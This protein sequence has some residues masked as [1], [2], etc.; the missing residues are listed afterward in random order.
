[1]SMSF[2]SIRASF[3]LLIFV[4]LLVSG[5]KRG[6]HFGAVPVSGMVTLDGE[7]IEGVSITF[8]P[9]SDPA[10]TA[11]GMSDVTGKFVLTTG[12]SKFGT[13]AVPGDYNVILSK[14][15][16]VHKMVSVDE[17]NAGNTGTP[18]S[19]EEAFKV[20]RHIPQK[21][22]SPQTSGIEPVK[23]EKRKKNVLNFDLE[24]E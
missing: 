9:L 1:M 2:P 7:P 21:Y 15:E 11:V 12:S 17:L 5:C 19:M 14:T 10:M 20:I 24:S 8:S 3:Y 23:I 18:R 22:E 6:N 4:L 16:P 13:G